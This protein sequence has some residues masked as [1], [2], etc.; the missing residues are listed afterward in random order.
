MGYDFD[1]T[2]GHTYVDFGDKECSQFDMFTYVEKSKKKAPTNL[3]IA[4]YKN[5]EFRKKFMKSYEEYINNFMSMDKI[6][7]IIEIFKKLQFMFL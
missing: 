6:N 2:M 5:E 4:L 3:F 1:Y 7:P